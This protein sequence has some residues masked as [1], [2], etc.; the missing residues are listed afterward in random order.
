MVKRKSAKRKS[1]KRKSVKRKSVKRKSAKQGGNRKDM[2][3]RVQINQQFIRLNPEYG[4]T[5]P[6][7]NHNPHDD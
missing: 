2:V 7:P 5:N 6:Y 4:L 1:A 3:E